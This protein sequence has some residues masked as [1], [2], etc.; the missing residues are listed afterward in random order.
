MKL[1]KTIRGEYIVCESVQAIRKG[2]SSAFDEEHT[3]KTIKTIEA[4][5]NK[6]G[7]VLGLYRNGEYSADE[8]Q[9]IA[10]AELIRRLTNDQQ[11]IEVLTDEQAEEELKGRGK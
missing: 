1:I 11:I 7:F 8:K 9:K 4:I 10:L 5:T 2:G 3:Y 6:G